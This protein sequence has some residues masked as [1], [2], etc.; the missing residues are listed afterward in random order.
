LN[1]EAVRDAG[2]AVVLRDEELGGP[3]LAGEIAALVADPGRRERLAAAAR[4]LAR[5]DAA[6]RIADVADRLMG[7][8]GARDVS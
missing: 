5:P 2:A 7:L 4:T 6:L 8:G 1:A 3:R